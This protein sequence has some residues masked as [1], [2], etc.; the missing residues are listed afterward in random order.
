[1][2]GS[3]TT[4]TKLLG[5]IHKL[6]FHQKVQASDSYFYFMNSDTILAGRG[7][8]LSRIFGYSLY[9]LH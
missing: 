4:F 8:K 7:K 2:D 5:S 6:W 3:L 1:M 9:N